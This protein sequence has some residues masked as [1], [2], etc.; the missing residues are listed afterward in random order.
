[1]H[2]LMT[3]LRKRPEITTEQF[4]AYM[5]HEYG[6]TYSA[7]PQTREYVQ[8]FLDDLATDEA[9][10]PIDAIVRIA[11]DSVDS[12]REALDSDSYRHAHEARKTFIRESSVGIHS[13][14]VAHEAKLV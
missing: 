2:I 9:E 13:A 11:F 8:Y 4:R 3:I 6:P 10:A 1:M 7:M 14:V 12:M 5:E